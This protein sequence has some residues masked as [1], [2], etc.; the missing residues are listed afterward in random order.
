MCHF[1]RSQLVAFTN[2]SE[3]RRRAMLKIYL[4]GCRFISTEPLYSEPT[5]TPKWHSDRL[6]F[7]APCELFRCR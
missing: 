7:P 1:T 6:V 4:E 5:I 2:L 3:M